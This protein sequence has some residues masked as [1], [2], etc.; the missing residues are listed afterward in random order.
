MNERIVV[1]FSDQFHSDLHLAILRLDYIY[2]DVDFHVLDGTVVADPIGADC[3]IG[4]RKA[5]NY[6]VYREH[7]WRNSS[8][9]R[10][11][12]AKALLHP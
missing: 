3:A 5:I 4:I 9:L 1:E 12:M 8:E 6:A 11:Q 10:N 7:I 2:P